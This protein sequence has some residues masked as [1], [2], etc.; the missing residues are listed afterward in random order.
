M[1][2]FEVVKPLR[3]QVDSA[4]A[5][6]KFLIESKAATS[7]EL[8]QLK[9]E[10]AKQVD[11]KKRLL[12]SGKEMESKLKDADARNKEKEF[13]RVGTSCVTIISVSCRNYSCEN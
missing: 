1:R 5:E 11:E 8:S 3:E 6:H 12:K 9:E 13:K 7:R 2:V 10:L 4:K